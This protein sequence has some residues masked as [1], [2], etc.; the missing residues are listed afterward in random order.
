M[1]LMSREMVRFGGEDLEGVAHNSDDLD[2][3]QRDKNQ[4]NNNNPGAGETQKGYGRASL[5]KCLDLWVR[6]SF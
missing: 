1:M 2:E 6:L 5:V 3:T 4:P